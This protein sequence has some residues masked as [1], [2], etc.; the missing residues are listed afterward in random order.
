MA[1]AA[2]K[3]R[4]FVSGEIGQLY[5]NMETCRLYRVK[6]TGSISLTYFVFSS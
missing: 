4:Q 2:A 1:S 3:M 6:G 5:L